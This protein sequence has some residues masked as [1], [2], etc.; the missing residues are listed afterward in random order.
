MLHTA[1]STRE[2]EI[3]HRRYRYKYIDR[4][5]V[6]MKGRALNVGTIFHSGMESF[7]A[8]ASVGQTIADIN[9]EANSNDYWATDDGQI[10]LPR[11]RAMIR[12]YFNKWENHRELWMPVEIERT[13]G[14]QLDGDAE[15][16]GKIDLLAKRKSDGKLFVWDHKTAS[17]E[18]A[19]VGTDFWQRLAIDRQ[20]TLYAE[21]AKQLYGERPGIMW[22]AVRKPL[23]RPRMKK[24]IA[25][26]KSETQTEYEARKAEQME[27]LE[28][29]EQRLFETM[30]ADRDSYFVR[31]EVHRTSDQSK[32]AMSALVETV[33]EIENYQGSY[34]KND[35][36]CQSRYGTCPYLGVCCGVETLDS[37]RFIQSDVTHPELE[38]NSETKGESYELDCP[39]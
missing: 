17:D 34:P 23:G 6:A 20:V 27:S 7:A 1:S 19:N 39:I 2:W 25:K 35:G 24:K 15:F 18:I 32:E 26:R 29:F 5:R 14:M 37:E 33:R 10:E 22:D 38:L 21:L 16:S 9:E 3:C 12:A 36:A 13:L 28:E 31:R 11:T 4:C 30:V 8:G